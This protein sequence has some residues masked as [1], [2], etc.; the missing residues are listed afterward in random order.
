MA[1]GECSGENRSPPTDASENEP[2][3]DRSLARLDPREREKSPPMP[4]AAR[5]IRRRL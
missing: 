4:A 2:S 5:E 1:S 3:A